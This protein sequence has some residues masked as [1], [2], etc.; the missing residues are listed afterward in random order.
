MVKK[1]RQIPVK[2]NEIYTEKIVDYTHEGLGVAKVDGYPVFIEEAM[3][4]ELIKF[5]IVK[6]GKNFSF[7]IIEEV[8]EESTDRVERI[9]K[10]YSQ[11]GT[12]NLQHMSY[13]A[14][15]K[16]KQSQVQN[17]IHKIAKID[18]VEVEE[19]IGMNFPY[20]YRNKAQVPVRE[21]GSGNLF[22]G[23]FRKRTHD[24]IPIENYVIQ[25]PA[26][27]DAIIKVRNILQ[28]FGLRGFDEEN[29]R[30]DIRHIL[31]RRGQFT[32]EMMIG[33]VSRTENLR[34]KDEIAKE[35]VKR[36]PNVVSVIRNI[37]TKKTNVILGD[38]F[39]VLYG[40]DAYHDYLFD[41]KFKISHQ[42][43]VP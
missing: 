14:Q 30:G 34:F 33:L 28:E 6:T 7:G 25:H 29:H 38:K 35:I 43:C 15:L 17:A 20:E 1:K 26:I 13:P 2:K 39:E 12:M 9:G 42:S 5:K 32:K 16:F 22:T 27:D 23:F 8:I 4:G 37:N 31:V 36:I 21:D 24:V 41:L 3:L 40:E 10:I 18:D 11:T 19:T